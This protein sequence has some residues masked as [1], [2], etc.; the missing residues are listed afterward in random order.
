[1]FL[2]AKPH[3][4]VKSAIAVMTF[5]GAIGAA[6]AVAFGW[7]HTG[8]WLG[9]DS[10]MQA[11]RWIGMAIAVCGTIVAALAAQKSD[12]RLTMRISLFGLAA[13]LCLQGFLGGELAHGAGHLG[14]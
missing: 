5:A 4:E 11:H 14:L 8:L 13:A 7:I 6:V 10:T 12:D 2:I 9:G 1:M 3:A